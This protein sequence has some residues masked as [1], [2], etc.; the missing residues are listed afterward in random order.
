MVSATIFTVT[1]V[2]GAEN[3]GKD[4]AYQQWYNENVRNRDS[5]GEYTGPSRGTKDRSKSNREKMWRK[6]PHSKRSP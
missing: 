6:I 5:D 2:N 1:M 3:A 4:K